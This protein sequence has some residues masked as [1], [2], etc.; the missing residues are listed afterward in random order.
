MQGAY[1]IASTGNP[2]IGGGWNNQQLLKDCGLVP[3]LL[4]KNYGFRS[5]MV[6]IKNDESYP[7]L[8]KYVCGLEMDFLPEDT[9]KARINYIK[10]HAADM[11]L[12]IL[13]GAYPAYIP[14]VK[15][16][17]TL[18][19]DGKIYLATDMNIA[20]A[21]R[22]PHE[23]QIYK[24]FLQSCDVVAASCRATQKYISTKWSVPVDLLRNGW[25]NF[26]NVKFND[27]PKENIILTVGRIGSQ[28]KQNHILLEAFAKVANKLPDWNLRLVG[29]VD[30]NFKTYTEK[31]FAQ[32]PNLRSRVTFTGLIADKATL[33]EEYKRAKIFCLTSNFEGAP[34]VIAE[35]LF[36]GDYIITSAVDAADDM[37]DSG[38]CGKIFP[39]GNVNA[40]AEIFAEVCRDD[41]L[42]KNGGRLAAANAAKNFDENK[43]VAKLY[44]LLYGGDNT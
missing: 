16:Y 11:D 19:P 34:N 13:Y 10:E 25:Y 35:A 15:F 5:V 29:G 43:I 20:W 30:K 3:Y 42:L 21:D 32:N 9:E 33:I 37:T 27:V 24:N 12:L 40:L 1:T 14:L 44:Y 28:Q 23:S 31:Y 41:K 17:K 36:S 8:D 6:G 26:F 39:I 2:E 38:N 18:R 7:Y 4:H 22:I